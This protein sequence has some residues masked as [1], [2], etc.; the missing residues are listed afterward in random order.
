MRSKANSRFARLPMLP[1]R[2]EPPRRILRNLALRDERN[3]AGV[4]IRK[5]EASF[6]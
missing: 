4:S 3:V 5:C 6:L 1:L 2:Y